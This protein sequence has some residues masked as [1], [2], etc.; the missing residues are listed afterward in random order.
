MTY[1]IRAGKT[2][3]ML[4]ALRRRKRYYGKPLFRRIAYMRK[5]WKQI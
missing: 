2:N 5:L 1:K 4:G 3:D